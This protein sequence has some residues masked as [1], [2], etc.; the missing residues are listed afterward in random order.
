[1]KIGDFA[2]YDSCRVRISSVKLRGIA[3]PHYRFSCVEKE[4]HDHPKEWG[5]LTSFLLLREL[6]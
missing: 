1:M 4:E 2:M 6:N 3:G 5:D